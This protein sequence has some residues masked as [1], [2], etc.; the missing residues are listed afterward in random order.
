MHEISADLQTNIDYIKTQLPSDMDT[1]L[2]RFEL[3]SGQQAASLFIDGLVSKELLGRDFY[4]PLMRE[5]KQPSSIERIAATV[6]AG[7]EVELAG[8]M[9]QVL[10]AVLQGLTALFIDGERQALLLEVISWPQRSVEEPST[11]VVI[12]GPREGYVESLRVNVSLLRRKIHHRDFRVEMF[13]LGRYS[14]TDVAVVYV[15]SIVNRDVLRMICERLRRIDIDAIL[16]SG[17][18]EQLIQDTPYSLFPTIGMGEKPDITAAKILEGRV[19]VLIDGSPS[20]LSAPMFFIEALHSPEDYYTRF[21]YASWL[22]I[23]RSISFLINV[24]LP[25]FFL[26]VCCH[27][28][29]M[30]PLKLLLSMSV[31]QAETPFSLGVSLLLISLVYEILKEAGV[32]LPKPAGQAISIVGAIIMGDAAIAAGLISA[33][34]LIVLSI[35]VVAA[36]VAAPLTDASS[37]LRLLFLVLGWFTGL[38]GMMLGTVAMLLYLG[39]LK[40]VGVDYFAPIAPFDRNEFKEVTL[41]Y[42]LWKLQFRPQQLSRNRRRMA[43]G[44]GMEAEHES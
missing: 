7:G 5:V 12:R 20:V 35:T 34:V 25:G 24:Y 13:R 19:A 23:I 31:A 6:I 33:P 2:R 29:E 41:R 43:S 14:Q 42:P 30:V 28:P 36:F 21:H 16:D 26:A 17:Q 9:Q 40:S 39:S 18:V 32:R 3:G 37:L 4:A 38:F 22:R 8:D 10:G 15:E 44:Q 27:H 11:D 1:V